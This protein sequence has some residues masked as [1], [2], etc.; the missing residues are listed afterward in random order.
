MGTDFSKV[1]INAVAMECDDHDL[2]KNERKTN[3]L[4]QNNF[5]C[6]LVDRN[7]MCRN[8]DFKISSSEHRTALKKW[9]G[10]KWVKVKE[11]RN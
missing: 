3:I 1:H 8:K 5:K 7:C 2:S 9:D 4:E 11:N 10:Q 6:E